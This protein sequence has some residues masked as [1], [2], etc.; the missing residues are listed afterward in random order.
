MTA[1]EFKW[2]P[3]KKAKV[4]KT[5]TGAYSDVEVRIITRDNYMDFL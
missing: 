5:F 1:Y 4:S 3:S 2:N